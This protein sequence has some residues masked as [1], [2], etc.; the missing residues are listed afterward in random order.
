MTSRPAS[1]AGSFGPQERTELLALLN[2]LAD[3]TLSE[4]EKRRLSELLERGEPARRMFREFAALHAGLHW[5]YA[6]LLAPGRQPRSHAG[7]WPGSA[8]PIMSKK[9][10]AATR[11]RM[12]R[13][14]LM[15]RF[16]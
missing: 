12:S 3:G 16:T 13:C 1:D 5:D 15:A 6:M 2:T 8:W 7:G 11:W 10:P 14:A 9:Q 4:A